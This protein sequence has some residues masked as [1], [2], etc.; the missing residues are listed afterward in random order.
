[1][2]VG[3]GGELGGLGTAGIDREALMLMS[4]YST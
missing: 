1:M 2:S 4:L 3:G